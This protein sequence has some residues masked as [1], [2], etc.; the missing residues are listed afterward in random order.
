MALNFYIRLELNG[1]VVDGDTTMNEIGGMDVSS[2]HLEGYAF[3]HEV[4][5]SM[6]SGAH[7]ASAHGIRGP[8]SFVKR[9][10][11]AS[12]LIMQAW[13]QNQDVTAWITFFDNDPDSGET[14]QRYRYHLT[15]GRIIAVR[16]EM[17]N[18]FL[19]EGQMAPVM[20]RVTIA[21]NALRVRDLVQN[22]EFE[23]NWSS[24]V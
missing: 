4:S 5:S 15:Q 8:V 19:P 11:Q 12:P 14:R 2:E 3:Y 6:E 24:N 17:L 23:D 13:A 7:R 20:E 1:S 9:I 10:D 21:Y 18:V 22:R 16:T